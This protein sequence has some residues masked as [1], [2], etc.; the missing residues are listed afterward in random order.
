MVFLT[1]N[2]GTHDGEQTQE[3]VKRARTIE[4]ADRDCQQNGKL[5]AGCD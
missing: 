1:E 3:A 4:Q 2:I 5:R